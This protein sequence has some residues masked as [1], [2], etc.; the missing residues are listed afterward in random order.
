MS[1]AEPTP[2]PWR[3]TAWTVF[4]GWQ[5]RWARWF[6]NP[7]SPEGWDEEWEH[8]ADRTVYATKAECEAAI[9]RLSPRQT[10]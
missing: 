8:S 10:A 1:A 7:R 5:P 4:G 2:D 3:L 9:A 6:Y